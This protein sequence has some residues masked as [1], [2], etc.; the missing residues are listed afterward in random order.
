MTSVAFCPGHITALFYAP[1]PGPTPERTG[2][3]G[4]GMCISLGAMATVKAVPAD[5]AS[6][7]TG[8]GTVLAPVVEVVDR[9]RPQF[10]RHLR[11][12]HVAELIVVQLLN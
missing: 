5:T 3:R 6:V 9:N 4:A 8:E 7:T 11:T 1:E 10:G 2:S 12:T